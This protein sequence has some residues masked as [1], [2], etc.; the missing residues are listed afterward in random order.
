L[1]LIG[2]LQL[3]EGDPKTAI[4]YLSKSLDI[5]P[6]VASYADLVQ[7]YEQLEQTAQAHDYAKLG[8][9]LANQELLSKR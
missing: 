4:Q 1:Q 2:H 5:M 3:A 6:N 7:A 8:L 9:I